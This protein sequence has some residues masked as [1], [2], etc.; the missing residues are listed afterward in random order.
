VQSTTRTPS[1]I[2]EHPRKGAVERGCRT[3]TVACLT[4]YNM[5]FLNECVGCSPI[6]QGAR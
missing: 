1:S 6:P 5:D 2:S 4:E 3:A